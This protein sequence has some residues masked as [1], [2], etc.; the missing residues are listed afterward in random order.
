MVEASGQAHILIIDDEPQIR[1][2]LSEL[3]SPDYKC[4]EAASAEEALDLPHTEQFDLILTDIVID[5]RENNRWLIGGERFEE[6]AFGRYQLR[7]ER[8][9]AGLRRETRTLASAWSLRKCA[10]LAS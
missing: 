1:G 3:L 6:A 4:V 9:L 10:P 7:D 8:A 5:A 2:I